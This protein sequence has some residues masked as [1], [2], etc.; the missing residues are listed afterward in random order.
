MSD[1]YTADVDA[2]LRSSKHIADAV[3]YCES[4]CADYEGC[5]GEEGGFDEFANQM[6]PQVRLEQDQVLTTLRSITDGFLA[7]VDAVVTEAGYVQ[8]PQQHA[9]DDIASLGAEG[10][11]RR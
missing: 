2:I 9:L 1:R 3:K 7:L 11:S 10:E 4:R 5:W 6:G 8:R